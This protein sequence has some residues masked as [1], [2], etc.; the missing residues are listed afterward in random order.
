MTLVPDLERLITDLERSPTKTIDQFIRV[1]RKL[2][3]VIKSQEDRIK[4]LE[5]ISLPQPRQRQ[6][7]TANGQSGAVPGLTHLNHKDF[8]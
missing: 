3:D 4:T 1:N 6:R 7:E 5:L 2:L 8:L